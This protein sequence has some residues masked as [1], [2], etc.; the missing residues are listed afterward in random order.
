MMHPRRFPLAL[1][2]LLGLSSAARAL[3]FDALRGFY[4][5]SE[6]R[7]AGLALAEDDRRTEVAT[8]R[9]KAMEASSANAPVIFQPP[10]F[11][12]PVLQIPTDPN[13]KFITSP[14]APNSSGG[15]ANISRNG[16]SMVGYLDR[17]PFTTYHG[18]LWS[19]AAGVTDLGTLDASNPWLSSIATDV[20]NSGS[21]VVGFADDPHDPNQT[22][23]FRWTAADGM[24]DLGSGSGPGGKSRANGV[25]GD[26]NVV[27]GVS[28]FPAGNR[29]FR[30]TAAGGFQNLGALSSPD[31]SVATAVTGDGSVVIGSARVIGP[32]GYEKQAFRWTEGA[33]MTSLG[34]L[35]G[36]T[37]SVATGVSDDG[38]IIVGISSSSFLDLGTLPGTYEYDPDDS[39][40]FYW[41]ADKGMQ[42]LTQL[43]IDAGA[44]LGDTT[45]VYASGISPDGAWIGGAGRDP[46][47]IFNDDNFIVNASFTKSLPLVS[48]FNGDGPA[49][50][51]DLAAWSAGF[52]TGTTQ[53]AGDGDLDGDVDGSDFL[54]WQLQ[55][56]ASSGATAIP[57]PSALGLGVMAWL[58]V[59]AR[60]PRA[61]RRRLDRAS[62]APH[63]RGSNT[64][65]PDP[66]PDVT[67][68]SSRPSPSKSAT[69]GRGKSS[70]C[71][72]HTRSRIPL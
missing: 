42:D 29:A 22:H 4:G 5:F 38:S 65:T 9:Q 66:S 40:A 30:W 15:A 67:A 71:A 7:L 8:A 20:A 50:G 47:A 36:H 31:G 6:G 17:G 18:F 12:I 19:E 41:T 44:P 59:A 52:H 28:S 24:I 61:A 10:P 35:P 64:S 16:Q 56:G 14:D 58:G 3:E 70:D 45:I 63:H 21:A 57:E 2:L 68:I 37:A 69:T 43:L 62:S 11:K 46:D 23:A 32:Q 34:V 72:R 55:V 53:P 13:A 60:R 49:N 27:V 48:D 33:G 1:A 51:A 25:S 26:G 54:V 39:R